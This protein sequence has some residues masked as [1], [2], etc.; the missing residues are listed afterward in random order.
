MVI[1]K[2][3]VF[4]RIRFVVLIYSSVA[5]QSP[6]LFLV[7]LWF[8]IFGEKGQEGSCATYNFLWVKAFNIH[9]HHHVLFSPSQQFCQTLHKMAIDVLNTADGAEKKIDLFIAWQFFC[10]LLSPIKT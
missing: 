9:L 7:Q 6:Y 10:G 8:H 5:Q 3:V 1:R 4:Q 2:P